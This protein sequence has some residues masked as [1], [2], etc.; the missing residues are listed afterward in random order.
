MTSR[1]AAGIDVMAPYHLNNKW[2]WEYLDGRVKMA[3]KAESDIILLLIW[4]IQVCAG[5]AL[6]YS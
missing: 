4:H 1:D 6:V 5:V 3:M 2:P